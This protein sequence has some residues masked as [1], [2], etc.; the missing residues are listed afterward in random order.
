MNCELTIV[1]SCDPS[2]EPRPPVRGWQGAC[3]CEDLIDQA[4]LA[5]V[6]LDL[7]SDEEGLLLLADVLRVLDEA[8]EAG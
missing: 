5:D 3:P 4:I 6:L 7:V 1:L 8:G 2:L